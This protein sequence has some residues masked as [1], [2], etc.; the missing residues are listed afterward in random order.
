MLSEFNTSSGIA[1]HFIKQSHETIR[2]IL[3]PSPE[4]LEATRL[5]ALNAVITSWQRPTTSTDCLAIREMSSLSKGQSVDKDLVLKV[6]REILQDEFEP[7]SNTTASLD[8]V[9]LSEVLGLIHSGTTYSSGSTGFLEKRLRGIFYTPALIARFIARQTVGSYLSR[10][11]HNQ[12]HSLSGFDDLSVLDPCCGSG[13]FL[14]AAFEAIRDSLSSLL[15]PQATSEALTRIS[16]NIC[17]VDIDPAALEIAKTSLSL[18]SHRAIRD[19]QFRVGN[20]LINLRGWRVT[21][22]HERFFAEP[23]SRTPFEWKDEFSEQLERGGF[24]ILLFNPPYSRLKPNRAEFMRTKLRAGSRIINMDEYEDHKLQMQEDLL[25]FRRS[26]EYA[27]SISASINTYHLFI[28]RALMLTRENGEIGFIV[29]STLLADASASKLRK[30]L[31]VNNCILTITEF[32][33]SARLFEQ[34]TQSVCIGHV[35][36]TGTT[37]AFK[38]QFGMGSSGVKHG[39]RS[40]RLKLQDIKR[41]FGESYAIPRVDSHDWKLLRKMHKHAPLSSYHWLRN[42]RGELDLTLDKQFIHKGSGSYLLLRGSGI[43]RYALSGKFRD[44]SEH[45]DY[46]A[47]YSSKRNSSRMKHITSLRIACQQVSN[48]QNHWRLKFAPVKPRIVLANSCNYIVLQNGTPDW[49]L[50][51]LMGVLNSELLNWRFTIASSNNHVSNREL[52]SL[53]VADPFVE[54]NEERATHIASLVGAI[55]KPSNHSHP[56]IEALVLSLY[57]FNRNEASKVLAY[58]KND[59]NTV[60]EIQELM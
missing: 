51:Y 22:S 2:K 59:K 20:S 27:S 39:T 11:G 42:H 10:I 50:Y 31:L 23:R 56:M 5:L 55:R 33:E 36:R 34:V 8:A 58:R 29:P 21:G 35:Q 57:G 52:A 6:I 9:M 14:V 46:N 43:G 25:Y 15:S 41:V 38:V 37:R 4:A 32:P 47:F 16:E 17:G 44:N 53:P 48:Q 12:A 18:A 49:V 7:E 26:G 19:E 40:Y 54:N 24:D 28:E 13:I 30:D 3:D 45:V 60:K 1:V